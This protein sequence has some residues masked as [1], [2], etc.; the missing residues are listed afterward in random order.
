[1]EEGAAQDRRDEVLGIVRRNSKAVINV[2]RAKGMTRKKSY[3][4]GLEHAKSSHQLGLPDAEGRVPGSGRKSSM[5]RKSQAHVPLRKL[6][7]PSA[8]S[9]P[10]E[11]ATK[12][13]ALFTEFDADGS[14]SID[15]AEL[16]T[17][18]KSLGHELTPKEL[19]GMIDP[20][21]GDGSGNIEMREFLDILA[22]L[23]ET[24][25]AGGAALSDETNAQSLANA[26]L[27]GKGDAAGQGQ[28]AGD[29]PAVDVS[30]LQKILTDDFDLHSSIEEMISG[31]ITYKSLQMFLLGD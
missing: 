24:Q 31:P 16:G 23:N 18:M 14:G 10:S 3:A 21:D 30:A 28:P 20:L 17:L 13:K 6:R 19:H 7:Q 12:A 26:L 5:A 1:M 22:K 2:N 25:P 9:L 8:P 11:L 15:A 27:V 29:D 4:V